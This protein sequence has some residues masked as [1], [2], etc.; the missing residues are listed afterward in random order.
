M[1]FGISSLQSALSSFPSSF[2]SYRIRHSQDC[3]H[4]NLED[5]QGVENMSAL[6][7]LYFL[8]YYTWKSLYDMEQ[9]F[10]HTEVKSVGERLCLL[11]DSEVFFF[12]F[13]FFF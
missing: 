5:K 8:P 10:V 1:N 2:Y 12:V 3:F 6:Q 4:G 9:C 7:Y 11:P 13:V